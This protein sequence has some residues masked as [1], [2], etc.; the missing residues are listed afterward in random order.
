MK[1]PVLRQQNE[2]SIFDIFAKRSSASKLIGLPKLVK[3][4]RGNSFAEI[5]AKCPSWTDLDGLR[6]EA[7]EEGARIP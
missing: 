1:G 3:A 6:K 2:P 7:Y 4:V 5:K